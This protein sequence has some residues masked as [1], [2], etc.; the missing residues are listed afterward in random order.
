MSG[1]F[2]A[3]T[4]PSLRAWVDVAPQSDFPIQNLPYGAFLVA[5][6]PVPHLGVAIGDRIFDLRVVTRAGLLDDALGDAVAVF[7]EP[8]LNMFLSRGRPAWRAVR[9]ELSRLLAAGDR[10]ILDAG[11]AE[12][13]LVAQSA[14]RMVLPISV[15][16]YVDFYSSREHATNL[17]RILRPNQE[18]LL[19]NWLWLP[20]GYHGRANTVVVSG[21]PIVRPA[22]QTKAAGASAPEFGPTAMLDFELELGFITGDG[23]PGGARIPVGDAAEYVFGMALVNDWSAR[24]IQAWE[25]QPLGPFLGKSFATSLGPWIVTLDALEPFRVD[26]PAQD[27]PPL[28][29]LA[30]ARAQHFDIALVAELASDRMRRA[31][32]SAQAIARTNARGLYWSMAQQLAHLTSNGSRVTAGDLCASGTISGSEPGSYGSMIELTLRGER[33]LDLADGTTRAFLEDGDAVTLRGRCTLAGA[34]SIGLGEVSGT[35]LPAL[36]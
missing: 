6:D 35:V 9:A 26:G 11:V 31:G 20:I 30:G 14:A 25:Y 10:R 28:P 22:G 8:T 15:V 18:P 5:G 13:A 17:G 29:Y 24:D 12:R 3:T 36:S 1:A 4:D 32:T 23:P 16:D 2:D 34:V 33:P 21:T 19:P 7:A 27:P